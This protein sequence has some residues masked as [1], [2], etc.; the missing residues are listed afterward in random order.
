ME[1][2]TFPNFEIFGV[3]SILFAILCIWIKIL[4]NEKRSIE[5]SAND[6]TDSLMELTT[7]T[8]GAIKDT[9]HLVSAVDE[10]IKRSAGEANEVNRVLL[11]KIDKININT[12]PKK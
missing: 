6:L 7:E 5:R 10:N 11:E 12:H 2:L 1:M 9:N 8:I 3:G 4:Y